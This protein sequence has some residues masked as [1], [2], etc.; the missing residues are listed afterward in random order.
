MRQVPKMEARVILVSVPRAERVPPLILRLI[1]TGRRLRSSVRLRRIVRQ[2]L[3]MSHEDEEFLDVVTDASA[4]SGLRR[5]RVIQVGTAQRQQSSF[6]GQL[7]GA[8]CC[9]AGWVKALACW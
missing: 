4:Q 2:H 1:T 6:Q 8:P 3:R 9:S 7:G 5:R